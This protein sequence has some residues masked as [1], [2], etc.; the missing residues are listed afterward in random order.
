MKTEETLSSAWDQHLASEFAAQS[1]DQALATMTASPHVNL[2]PLMIGVR[3]RR[4]AGLL[5][6]PLPEPDPAGHGDGPRLA[7]QRAG[8]GGR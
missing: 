1:A 8:P 6:E 2:V 4:A 5:R 7:D 3:G